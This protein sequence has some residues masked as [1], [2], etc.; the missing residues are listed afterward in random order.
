MTHQREA[1][2]GCNGRTTQPQFTKQH[3]NTFFLRGS[4]RFQQRP[5]EY[6]SE[7]KPPRRIND[8]GT[9]AT[10]QPITL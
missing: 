5:V 6:T 2:R 7:R 8:H 4:G 1:Q 3:K 10:G 9:H